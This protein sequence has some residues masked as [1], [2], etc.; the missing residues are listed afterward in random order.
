[1]TYWVT[2]NQVL[3]GSNWLKCQSFFGDQNGYEPNERPSKGWFITLYWR[4][5]RDSSV[6]SGD[7]SLDRV[8]RLGLSLR[9][10]WPRARQ[11][12]DRLP[13]GWI[14]FRAGMCRAGIE[15]RSP[16]YLANEPHGVSLRHDPSWPGNRMRE[17]QYTTIVWCL[18]WNLR[19]VCIKFNR[20]I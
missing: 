17:P 8:L 3:L 10:R 2:C 4:Y 14:D 5:I 7:T 1:M 11:R 12:R 15:L 9:K 19:L 13:V 18:W 20:K 16:R 6:P